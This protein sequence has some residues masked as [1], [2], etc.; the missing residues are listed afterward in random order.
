MSV[1]IVPFAGHTL[2][3][4]KTLAFEFTERTYPLG[5]QI[6]SHTHE[7][8]YLGITIGGRH[9]Q[10]SDGHVRSCVPGTVT[11]HPR[12]DTHSD[13]FRGSSA[14]MLNVKLLHPTLE[15]LL[16][17][18]RIIAAPV[19]MVSNRSNWLVRTIRHEMRHPDKLSSLSLEG[20]GWELLAEALRWESRQYRQVL[21]RW[22]CQARDLIRDRFTEPLTIASI[23]AEVNVH[24]VHLAREFRHHFHRTIGQEIRMLRLEWCCEALRGGKLPLVAIALNSGFA[25]QS[26]LTRAFKRELGIAPAAFRR[27]SQSR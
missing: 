6:S 4:Y 1:P 7:E 14:R 13:S 26:S 18:H 9:D 24:P 15:D 22:L 23:A 21:P 2:A 3:R 5:L 20:L 17:N 8:P 16:G 11:F 25:D 27:L 10:K 19:E 12:G